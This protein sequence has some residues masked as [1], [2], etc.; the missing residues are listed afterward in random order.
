MQ[1]CDFLALL[2]KHMEAKL[3]CILPTPTYLLDN[4][5]HKTPFTFNQLS[6]RASGA[7][8]VAAAEGKGGTAPPGR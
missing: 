5:L 1:F 8:P 2:I 6:P 3:M 7:L 4:L